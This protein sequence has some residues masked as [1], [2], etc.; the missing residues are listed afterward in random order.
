MKFKILKGTVLYEQLVAIQKRADK[1]LQAS[2]KL[3]K[4]IGATNVATR[5]GRNLAGGVDAF[6][7]PYGKDP[8]A[9]LWMKPDRHNSPRLFY[10]R[11][12]KKYTQNQELHD[13]I[14]ALPVVT[15]DEYNA[16]IGFERHWG[17]NLTHYVTYGL[18]IH[19]DFAL[20]KISEGATYAPATEDMVEI[21]ESE[22]EK[23]KKLIKE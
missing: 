18:S 23:L 12:G 5:D 11:S 8:D 7:F 21:L 20:I 19:K 4:S 13:K 14:D 10:P 16:I 17:S 15:I 1:C 2:Q 22:Y 6:E 9:M 3:A